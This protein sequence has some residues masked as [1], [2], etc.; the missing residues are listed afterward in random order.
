MPHNYIVLNGTELRRFDIIEFDDEKLM[1]GP[2]DERT[3]YFRYTSAR[4]IGGREYTNFLIWTGINIEYKV[5]SAPNM[6]NMFKK[7]FRN[8]R[9]VRKIKN[10]SYLIRFRNYAQEKGYYFDTKFLI[11]TVFKFL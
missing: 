1:L 3:T 6:M 7:R 8:R 10:V 4:I 5:Y 9:L 2:I 11:E